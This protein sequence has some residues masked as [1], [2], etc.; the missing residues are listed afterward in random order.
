MG[1]GAGVHGGQVVAE[2]TP[3]DIMAT[4]QSLTGQ[5]LTGVRRVEVPA[6]RRP[7]NGRAITVRNAREHNLHNVDATFPLGTLTCITGVSGGGKSTLVIETLYK[8][9]AR[10]LHGAREH[11]GAH[12]G[13][14]G[15]EFIDKVIDIDQSP[16]GRPPRPNPA[17][18]TGRSERR[19]VG[20]E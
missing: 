4:P 7:G 18:Y 5:Y 14:D 10:R 17:T 20:K 8:A 12:D 19:R 1:P 11:P 2:G 3:A 9:V 13:I 15:L 6:V 16:I